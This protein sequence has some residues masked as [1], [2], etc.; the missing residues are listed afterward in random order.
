MK[1]YKLTT[2]FSWLM[3]AALVGSNLRKWLFDVEPFSF[4]TQSNVLLLS[5]LGFF[6]IVPWAFKKL[7]QVCIPKEES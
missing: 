3:I 5:F 1:K 2:F 4:V 6:S 7:V